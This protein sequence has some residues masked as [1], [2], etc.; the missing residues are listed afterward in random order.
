MREL[1]ACDSRRREMRESCRLPRDVLL[2]RGGGAMVTGETRSR[3]EAALS[4]VRIGIAV[5]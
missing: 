3:K 4:D 1:R 5:D 2:V